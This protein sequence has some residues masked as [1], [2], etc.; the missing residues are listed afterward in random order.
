M[1]VS[2]A[3]GQTGIHVACYYGDCEAAISY[4]FDA[5]PIG[6]R[7]IVSNKANR[8]IKPN[9]LSIALGSFHLNIANRHN[10]D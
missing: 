3:F 4:T 8:T 2:V 9:E 7:R 6:K 1:W 10:K 5:S